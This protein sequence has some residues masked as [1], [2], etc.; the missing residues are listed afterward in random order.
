[1]ERVI[2]LLRK[3]GL[4]PPE[5]V[6]NG[7]RVLGLRVWG[8]LTASFVGAEIISGQV[9]KNLLGGAYFRFVD[10]S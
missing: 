9:P 2:A 7:A 3:Y 8:S 5:V 4:E 10:K 1:M 6:R